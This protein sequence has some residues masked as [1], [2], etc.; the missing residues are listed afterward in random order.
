MLGTSEVQV[1]GNIGNKGL[2][3]R[4]RNEEM[5]QQLEVQPIT[6]WRL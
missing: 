6:E 5:G 4:V 3:D 1:L 2:R